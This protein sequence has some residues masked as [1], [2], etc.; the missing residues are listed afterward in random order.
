MKLNYD[1]PLS[2][3]AFKFTLRRYTMADRAETARA[4]FELAQRF[5]LFAP[6][7]VLA[8][9]ALHPLMQMAAA[10][11]PLRHG[12]TLVHFSAQLEPFLTLS[13]P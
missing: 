10:A 2:D 1:E 5:A 9:P 3:F 7:Q 4:T 13:T 12:L 8:S 11:L 6:A